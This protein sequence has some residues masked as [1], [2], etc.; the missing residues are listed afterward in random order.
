MKLG[1][2]KP[3]SR[4][5]SL[6]AVFPERFDRTIRYV[7]QK[8]VFER[9]DADWVDILSKILKQNNKKIH[10]PTAMPPIQASLKK[11]EGFVYQNL[12]DK[13]NKTRNQNK[14]Y[15]SCLEQQ[16]SRK[17]SQNGIKLIGFIHFTKITDFFND[18]KPSY[19]FD[20]L[21]ERYNEALLKKTLT[22]KE[23]K[24]FE[25]FKPKLKHNVFTH[26]CLYLMI[27]SS[28]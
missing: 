5:S 24:S 11:I 22:K 8:P 10:F 25:S 3:Y 9:C 14:K 16:I 23:K 15:T 18:A 2:I 26:R 7:L 1:H 17:P 6:G 13:R 27:Y 12:L 20:N 28:N 19:R 4:N 21:L